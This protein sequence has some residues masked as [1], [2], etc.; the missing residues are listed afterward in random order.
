MRSLPRPLVPNLVEAY[1]RAG[2][3]DDAEAALTGFK[4]LAGRSG[5]PASRALLYGVAP[6]WR[7]PRTVSGRPLP[8]T[9]IGG[10]RSSVRARASLRRASPPPQAPRRCSNPAALSAD[11][12]RRGGRGRLGASDAYGVPGDRRAGAAARPIHARRPDAAGDDGR[13]TRRNRAHESRRRGT[14]LPQPQDDR[15]ASRARLPQDGCPC[16]RGARPPVR[17]SPDS[18]AAPGS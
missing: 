6:C 2:Q 14:P 7:S 3:R 8:S 1:L 5:R 13:S 16:A 12:V 18:I 17:D 11:D 9:S 15:D 4:A 10:T